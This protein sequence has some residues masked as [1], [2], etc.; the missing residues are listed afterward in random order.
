M[1]PSIP[2]SCCIDIRKTPRNIGFRASF[3]KI[4]IISFKFARVLSSS[5]VLAAT[6]GLVGESVKAAISIGTGFWSKSFSRSTFD[7][8]SLSQASLA[9]SLRPLYAS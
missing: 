9:S 7:T 6:V 3:L 5:F 1:T 4:A 2:L 8:P